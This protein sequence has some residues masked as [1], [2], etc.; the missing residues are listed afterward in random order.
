MKLSKTTVTLV[1]T[2]MA[3]V[4]SSDAMANELG[5]YMGGNAGQSTAKI[6]DA[7]IARGLAGGGFTTTSINDDN[8]DNGYKV[9]GGYLFNK[10]FAIEGGYFDLGKFGF[11]ATTLPPGTLNGRLK[12]RG[13]NLDAVLFMNMTERFSLFGRAGVAYADVRDNFSG[14]G[15][16][17]VNNPNP[18]KKDTNYKFGGGLQYAFNDNLAMR[19]EAER[20]RIDDAVGNKGDIDLVSL[21]L[22]YR[23]GRTRTVPASYVPPLASAPAPEPVREVFVA[24]PPLP[25]PP[26]PPARPLPPRFERFTLSATELFGFDSAELRLPHPKLDEIATALSNNRDISNVAIT[27]HADRIGSPAYNQK[28][29]ERRAMSV[30]DYLVSRGVD[31]SRLTASGRGELVPVVECTDKNRPALIICLEPNRRVEIEQITIDRRVQ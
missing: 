17:V 21:G 2:A 30:K 12:A 20:Y 24:P 13:A 14:T 26:A 18:S 27:G 3:A 28:L 6:D 25:T 23:F 1:L 9:F 19:L 10:H 5:W 8:R 31:G 7:R 29:S 11:T 22:V 15:L 4:T 16:V